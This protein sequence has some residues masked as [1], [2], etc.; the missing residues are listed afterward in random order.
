MFFE[1][2]RNLKEPVPGKIR[3]Q[4]QTLNPLLQHFLQTYPL[5]EP[6][7]MAEL[8]KLLPKFQPLQ[9]KNFEATLFQLLNARN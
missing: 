5:E 1:Q 8:A 2:L 4:L 3:A 9:L 7:Y 6:L